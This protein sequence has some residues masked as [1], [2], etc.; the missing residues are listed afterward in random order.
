MKK[1]CVPSNGHGLNI[2]TQTP[3]WCHRFVP[4][5]GRISASGQKPHLKILSASGAGNSLYW[6]RPV[7]KKPIS[8]F[9][10]GG[11]KSSSRLIFF[12]QWR[13]EVP[14]GGPYRRFGQ[15]GKIP[16]RFSLANG[17]QLQLGMAAIAQNTH[18]SVFGQWRRELLIGDSASGQTNP[19]HLLW[20]AAQGT[21]NRRFGRW[22]ATST[23]ACLANVRNN[24][25]QVSPAVDIKFI[26][27]FSA[28]GV[29]N[30]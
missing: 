22:T 15:R 29:G 6:I 1:R 10:A 26:S 4:R 13:G 14:I 9:L 20:A 3:A 11:Q 5:M 12:G 28:G 27:F 7:D 18:A 8:V 23:P 30:C 2:H 16:S 24:S 25:K 17:R 21:P 19:S